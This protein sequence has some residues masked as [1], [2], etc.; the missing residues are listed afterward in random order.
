ML[1]S[2]QDEHQNVAVFFIRM[3]DIHDVLHLGLSRM[4]ERE[5][6]GSA[7]F[8]PMLQGDLLDSS[9]NPCRCTFL[10]LLFMSSVPKGHVW[11]EGDNKLNSYDSRSFGPIPY[12]LLK[13]KIFWMVWPCKD[14]GSLRNK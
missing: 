14:F 8:R 5:D 4:N 9:Q 7:I 3:F 1:L 2:S 10:D 13:S 11:V 12:G 6:S